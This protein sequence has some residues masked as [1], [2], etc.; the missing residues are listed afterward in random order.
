MLYGTTF[1]PL[2]GKT[3]DDAN[4]EDYEVRVSFHQ[5]LYPPCPNRLGL[6]KRRL[7]TMSLLRKWQLEPYWGIFEM[8]IQPYS[9]ILY[10]RGINTCK[11]WRGRY[12]EEGTAG[13]WHL[14]GDM[15]LSGPR[16]LVD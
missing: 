8:S 12:K 13:G 2:I 9:G 16:S 1:I 3:N 6:A 11:A 5:R 15:S 10:V 7:G 4:S 14:K